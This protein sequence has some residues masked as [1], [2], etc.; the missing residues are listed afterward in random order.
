MKNKSNSAR[1]N[2]LPKTPKIPF[3][4][5]VYDRLAKEVRALRPTFEAL[6]M[7]T[8]SVFQ[9]TPASHNR[10]LTKASFVIIPINVFLEQHTQAM[11]TTA[12]K[13]KTEA[14]T[15]SKNRTLGKKQKSSKNHP[16]IITWLNEAEIKHKDNLPL[17]IL[18]YKKAQLSDVQKLPRKDNILVVDQTLF[19]SNVLVTHFL[20]RE[21][22]HFKNR[23]A[24]RKLTSA[25]P[26]AAQKPP[27]EKTP[28]PI[29]ENRNIASEE[30]ELISKEIL[31]IGLNISKER[32]TVKI[33]EEILVNSMRITQADA[34]SIAIRGMDKELKKTNED[35]LTFYISKNTS[36]ELHFSK[37]SMPVSKKSLGGYTTIT[38]KLLNIKDAYQI[39]NRKIY[40]FNREFDEKTHFR[41]KS[42]IVV[43]MINQKDET[44]GIIQLI[45]K[46]ASYEKII[47]YKNF[48]Q[49]DVLS[50]NDEDVTKLQ[51]LASLATI[52]LQNAIL[53]HEIDHLFHSF[54]EASVSAVEQ[55]DPATSGHSFRV[56]KFS[57]LLAEACNGAGGIFSDWFFTTTQL[58]ELEYAS[59]LHDFG[60]IG[61]RE[62]VLLKSHKIEQTRFVNLIRKFDVMIL[63]FQ[64]QSYDEML[65]LF[66]EGTKNNIPML[67]LEQKMTFIKTK[68]K[69]KIDRLKEHKKIIERYNEGMPLTN[70]IKKI[71]QECS[72][73]DVDAT[74]FKEKLITSEE[75][76]FLSIPYGTLSTNERIEIQSHVTHT[77]EF[78]KK[79]PWTDEL[80]HIPEI[81]HY[82]HEKLDGSGYPIG[83]KA[84]AIP[85]QTKIMT[86]CD[87]Y[88]ALTSADRPYKKSMNQNK[89][90]E[91]LKSE[92]DTGKLHPDL[93]ELFIRNKHIR[94]AIK[95]NSTPELNVIL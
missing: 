36:R 3:E 63:N 17:V 68:W 14:K 11:T 4:V 6:G 35:V 69:K 81:A 74:F 15:S 19:N 12:A 5:L 57:T 21:L 86:I 72:Y 83:I 87:I 82:H 54:V 44:I 29:T 62:H 30:R 41:T 66:R 16:S 24:A 26:P 71:I 28:A 95:A 7:K 70:E 2:T 27:T 46:K 32:D 34:G 60:K 40:S 22:I 23:Q 76:K 53:Y 38:G 58:R 52:S 33:L 65:D 80:K 88:D 67:E 43:P 49:T 78:L 37:F 1:L 93:L 39:S 73:L 85:N 56:S 77:F 79:I 84:I 13:S 20:A 94:N 75:E 50:F 92:R 90:I 45:N 47:D 51:A 42:V 48:K 64:N 55:R 18:S 59:L 91:I 8:L 10:S 25:P 31:N 61:V 89:A 9:T